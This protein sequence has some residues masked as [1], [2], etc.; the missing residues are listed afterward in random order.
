[1]FYSPPNTVNKASLGELLFLYNFSP[2]ENILIIM[3]AHNPLGT[4]FLKIPGQK[5]Y[6]IH[7][8]FQCSISTF[9]LFYT[10]RHQYLMKRP[11][12]T[13]SWKNSTGPWNTIQMQMQLKSFY[14]F[15]LIYGEYIHS[16]FMGVMAK[17]STFWT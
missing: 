15:S 1:M 11:W 7:F 6:F 2:L 12:T 3:K 14:K 16:I 9:V 8:I 5:S 4:A 10:F 13:T 17:I